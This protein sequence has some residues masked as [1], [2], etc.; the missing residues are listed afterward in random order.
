MFGGRPAHKFLQQ[1][2]AARMA[3]CDLIFS[4][5]GTPDGCDRV[6]EKMVKSDLSIADVFRAL[7]YNK[8][9]PSNQNFTSDFVM[10]RRKMAASKQVVGVEMAVAIAL[11][12]LFGAMMCT[13][14]YFME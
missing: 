8:S 4:T 11:T 3:R 12:A 14:G 5:F 9:S 2:C 6:L 1:V 10:G 7:Q 13:R